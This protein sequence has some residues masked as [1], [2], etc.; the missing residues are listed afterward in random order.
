M[1]PGVFKGSFHTCLA[2]SVFMVFIVALDVYM[3]SRS[4]SALL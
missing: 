4:G 2:C 1:Q 3:S